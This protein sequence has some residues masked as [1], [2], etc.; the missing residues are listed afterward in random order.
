M[1]AVLAFVV[2]VIVLVLLGWVTIRTNGNNQATVTVETEKIEKD[3]HQAIRKGGEAVE[4]AG[5]KL[6]ETIDKHDD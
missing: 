5:Q 4:N 6:Q 1:R 2:I 3:T